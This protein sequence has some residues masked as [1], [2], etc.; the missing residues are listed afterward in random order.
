[1]YKKEPIWL[2]IIRILLGCLFLFSS[3]TKA[4]DPVNFGITMNDYFVSFG[5]GFL[6]PLAQ[7]AAVCAIACEFILGCMLLFRARVQ[8]ASWGYLLFMVFFFFLTLWLAV[9]EYLE[10]KGIHNFGVVHDC[11]CFGQAVK[12]T[13]LGTF[14]KNVVIIIPTIILF[15]NRKRIPDNRMT[16]L[17]QW[18]SV[19]VFAAITVLFQLYC[20][21]HLPLIDF[22]DWKKGKDVVCFID[23][24]AQKD[25]IFVYKNKVDNSLVELTQDELMEQSDDFFGNFDYVDRK[26]KV[27]KERVA[28]KI[29]G[30]NMLDENGADHA[31]ELISHENEEDLYVLYMSDLSET[32]MKGVEKAKKLAAECE[33]K[34]VAFVAVSNSPEEEIGKFVEANGLT[35]PVYHNPIDPVHGP[36]M[37]RDAVRSNPGIILIKKG[38]VADKWAW[39]D[40]PSLQDK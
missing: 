20:I 2:K 28:P 6:H 23:Q 22:T 29:D 39:R 15:V 36:F 17:G 19:L 32:N 24:P 9:A 10:V 3:F 25:M 5:M 13:N 12:M 7:F 18:V 34:G 38:V 8:L 27:I 14:L 21:R 40:F 35:F 16:V 33:K 37:V 26:D 30:F 31:Y 11:G 1:M 4:V